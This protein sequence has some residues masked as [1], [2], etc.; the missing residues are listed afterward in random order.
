MKFNWNSRYRGLLLL[1]LVL[2]LPVIF[3]GFFAPSEYAAQNRDL[4]FAQPTRLHFV[5]ETGQFHL[6]PF[7]FGWKETTDAS[8][9][10]HYQEEKTTRYALHFF[11]RNPATNSVDSDSQAWHLFGVENPGAI[12]FFGCDG[13]GR[14]EFSR[15]LYGGRI[16]L[17]AGLFATCLALSLAIILGVVSGFYGQ[18]I[19][20]LVMRAVDIFLALP[21]L[22]LLFAVRAVLPLH[23]RT[24]ETFLLFVSIIGIVGWA[25]PARLVRGLVLSAKE[26]NF[27]LASRAFGASDFHILRRHILPQLSGTLLTLTALLLPQFLLAEVTLSFLGLGVGE[28]I[29][30]LG[31]LLSEL[32]K[33][34]VLTSYWWMYLPAVALVFLFLTY[35]W[36][37]KALQDKFAGVSL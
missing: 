15:M 13:F 25:R 2:H 32:Q 26:R 22:Y 21:W 6:R 1:L 17:A 8:G 28:P 4:P 10:S 7:V 20:S 9:D 18:W 35:H 19:D 34:S 24:T 29:P 12:H 23:I 14:D 16:S 37:A 30:S 3:P 27:V 5:D 11:V 33:Y 36:T 31:N